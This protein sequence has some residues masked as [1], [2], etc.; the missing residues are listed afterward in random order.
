MNEF[1]WELEFSVAFSTLSPS[2]D[3]QIKFRKMMERSKR[4]KSSTLLVRY[5]IPSL[6]TSPP[7]PSSLSSDGEETPMDCCISWQPP[8]PN[9][10]TD[11]TSIS[12]NKYSFR[13]TFYAHSFASAFS[14][15]FQRVVLALDLVFRDNALAT[16]LILAAK[17]YSYRKCAV[18]APLRRLNSA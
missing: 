9:I 10:V 15:P 1:P 3:C 17:T 16:P 5:S 12:C 14:S 11:A 13:L 2:F 18:L 8:P 4:R 7:F 6:A